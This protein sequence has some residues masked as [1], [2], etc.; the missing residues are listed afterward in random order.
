MIL[1]EAFYR[2]LPNEQKRFDYGVRTDG[3]PVYCGFAKIG[4]SAT[5]IDWILMFFKY[6]AGGNVTEEYT[7][8]GAWDSR[9]ALFLPYV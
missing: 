9:A 4:A 5:D 7:I 8:R 1:R 6:D 3:Q 2:N